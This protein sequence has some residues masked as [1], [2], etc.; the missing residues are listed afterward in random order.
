MPLFIT[1]THP[2]TNEG[3]HEYGFYQEGDHIQLIAVESSV[4]DVFVTLKEPLPQLDLPGSSHVPEEFFRFIGHG[5]YAD[6]L[7]MDGQTD[8]A[9]AEEGVAKFIL[10]Q[11]LQNQAVVQNSQ[12]VSLRFRTNYSTAPSYF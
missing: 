5:A 4:E 2:F 6:F 12:F 1:K 8:K 10:S 11:E 3:T 7:R 9:M